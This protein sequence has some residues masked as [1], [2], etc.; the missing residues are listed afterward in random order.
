MFVGAFL[1]FWIQPMFSKMVLPL[2][3]G[4]PNVW[5]TAMLF[6]QTVL[7]AGYGYAHLVARFVPRQWQLV[8]HLSVLALG[9]VSMPISVAHIESFQDIPILWLTIMMGASIGLPFF[10]VSATAPLVQRWF[11]FSGHRDAADPYFLY[12][13]S[14]LGSILVLLG[15]PVVMEP[16]LRLGEQSWGWALGYGLLIALIAVCGVHVLRGGASVEPALAVDSKTTFDAVTGRQ[17][18]L[19]IALAFAPSSLLLGVTTQI[20]TDVAAVPLLWVFP[21]ALYLL[22][23]VITFARRPLLRHRWMLICQPYV[24]VPAMFLLMPQGV[25]VR[26]L[27][28]LAVFFVTAMVCHGELVRRRPAASHLTE[29]YLWMSFGGMLGGVFNAIVAPL[30]FN[31][32]YEFV[33]ALFVACLLRPGRFGGPRRARTL[34]FVL[35]ILLFAF[36]FLPLKVF[37]INLSELHSP[38]Y[39]VVFVIAAILVFGAKERPL[40]FG[41][42]M[43]AMLLVTVSVSMETQVLERE[44][45]FFG[46]YKISS[47]EDGK[48]NLLKFGTTFHGAQQTDPALWRDPLLYYTREGPVGQVFAKL[49]QVSPR[50][51]IG[52][53]GLGVGSMLCYSRPG[54]EWTIYEIDPLIE[55]IAKDTRYFHYLSACSDA[56]KVRTVYGDARHALAREGTGLF[57]LLVLDAFSS[58]AVPVHLLTREALALYRETLKPGGLILFHISNRHLD[59]ETVLGRLVADAGMRGVVQRHAQPKTAEWFRAPSVWAVIGRTEQ[60]LAFLGGDARW[61]PMRAQDIAAVWTDDFSNVLGVFKWDIQFRDLSKMWD[62]LTH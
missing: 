52:I 57:D 59:L 18:L 40:R 22:T 38:V 11:A 53:V 37:S 32:V 49:D 62:D 48:V 20:T 56:P 25:W 19:W 12:A 54:Q 55:K 31:D 26:F 29:F 3:G 14:N 58:D 51:N 24:L 43:G 33:V 4:A 45:N 8:L 46:I 15:Y 61:E 36:V 41:L 13:A 44:R 34:D 23:Y 5:I 27:V 7:L 42:G 35:P 28:L 16:F 17:R 21:L 10:A 50:R 2:L 60:D 6:F 9:F 30:V 39:I 47:K 1:L